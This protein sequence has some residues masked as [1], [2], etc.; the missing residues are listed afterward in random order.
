MYT[1]IHLLI[2][3]EKCVKLT[4][5]IFS[6]LLMLEPLSFSYTRLV[7]HVTTPYITTIWQRNFNQKKKFEFFGWP[8][9]K[10]FNQDG[11]YMGLNKRLVCI[12]LQLH[13]YIYKTIRCSWLPIYFSVKQ[14]KKTNQIFIYSRGNAICDC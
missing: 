4:L 8:K 2:C 3:V 13:C 12:L 1:Y 11:Y 10:D 7:C 6:C 14:Y 9:K 5:P